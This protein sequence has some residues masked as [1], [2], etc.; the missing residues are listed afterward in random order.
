MFSR[1]LH[2]YCHEIKQTEVLY[3][4]FSLLRVDQNMETVYVVDTTV[5]TKDW[6]TTSSSCCITFFYSKLLTKDTSNFNYP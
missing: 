4:F 5:K 6:C 1:C 2:L 3:I